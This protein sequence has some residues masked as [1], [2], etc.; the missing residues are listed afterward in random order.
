MPEI[1]LVE[2]WMAVFGLTLVLTKLHV[3][4]WFREGVSGVSDWDFDE[5]AGTREEDIYW[6][7]RQSTIGRLLRCPA[8]MGFWVGAAMALPYWFDLEYI[9]KLDLWWVCFYCFVSGLSASAF[10]MAG[11]LVFKKLGAERS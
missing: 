3:F 9:A 4:K 7:F 1:S 10:C 11:W 5:M 6:E 2:Y 8:C